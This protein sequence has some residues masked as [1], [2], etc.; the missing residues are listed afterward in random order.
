MASEV[1]IFIDK[2][3]SIGNQITA[4][5]NLKAFLILLDSLAD[6]LPNPIL[7]RPIKLLEAV[8]KQE[9]IKFANLKESAQNE[10]DEKQR[11]IFEYAQYT[12]CE[13]IASA[14][15]VLRNYHSLG[16]DLYSG[17]RRVFYA[18]NEVGGHQD[19]IKQ[20]VKI[21]DDGKVNEFSISESFWDLIGEQG[22]RDTKLLPWMSLEKIIEFKSKVINPTADETSVEISWIMF[23]SYQEHYEPRYFSLDELKVHAQTLITYLINNISLGE[24]P[25][26][27][28][29]TQK[30]F[31]VK[32]QKI[33]IHGISSK[34]FN[35][36][37][38]GLQ[39]L[40]SIAQDIRKPLNERFI[41]SILFFKKSDNDSTGAHFFEVGKKT[42]NNVPLDET[43][44]RQI[45]D[46]VRDINQRILNELFIQDFI[47]YENE[48]IQINPRHLKK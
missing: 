46:L 40:K 6:T 26:E 11:I 20:H 31:A 35:R 29:L 45:R 22:R 16:L 5:N 21:R 36:D 17:V 48:I 28:K 44:R 4:T 32:S 19:F 9:N 7:T 47:I 43:E 25:D 24:L 42:K 30:D 3:R 18:L 34:P 39:L 1:T 37:S 23:G 38:K 13:D 15:D 14:L 27:M 41:H 10:L 33:I 8:S 12:N 2:L